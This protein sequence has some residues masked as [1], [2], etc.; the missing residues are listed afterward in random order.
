MIRSHRFILKPE[1]LN[2]NHLV[3]SSLRIDL[4][5]DCCFNNVPNICL[6]IAKKSSEA[7]PPDVSVYLLGAAYFGFR[8][9]FPPQFIMS[10]AKIQPCQNKN[11]S[12]ADQHYVT[13]IENTVT[14]HGQQQEFGEHR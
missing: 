3:V 5:L 1:S 2:I 12:L 10:W 7:F 14:K 13:V 11:N 8:C 4:K 9:L 6:H